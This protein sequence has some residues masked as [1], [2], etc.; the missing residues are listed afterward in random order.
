[1]E[2]IPVNGGM[3]RVVNVLVDAGAK[4]LDFVDPP[5]EKSAETAPAIRAQVE[6]KKF[7]GGVEIFYD[8]A[9]D[10]Y[11]IR[12]TPAQPGKDGLLMTDIYFDELGDALQVCIDDESWMG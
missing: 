10:T 7:A 1:M 8:R 4:D 6:T 11:G 5:E 9:A 12:L 3:R 2:R